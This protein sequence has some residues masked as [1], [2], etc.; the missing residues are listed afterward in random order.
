MFFLSS[1]SGLHSAA[2]ALVILAMLFVMVMGPLAQGNPYA[3]PAS[4]ALEEIKGE[5]APCAPGRL[6]A[7]APDPYGYQFIDSSEPGG[8]TFSWVDITATGTPLLLADDQY[9]GPFGIGFDFPLYGDVFTLFWVSSNGWINF[10]APTSS[11]LNNACPITAPD[12]AAQPSR[13]S[14]MHDD[15]DPGD[16]GDLLH[17]Q[18]FPSSPHPD[19]EGRCL[20]VT[21]D[22]YMH[23]N[24]SS[25][26]VA[27]TF[28]VLIFESGEIL[29]QFLDAGDEEGSG[30][31]T[32]IINGDM[33]IGLTYACNTP[34]SLTDNLAVRLFR[35]DPQER[36][37]YSIDASDPLLHRISPI[38]G[39][40]LRSTPI[41]LPGLEISGGTGLATHPQTG[42]LWALLTL[43]STASRELV[44][45]DPVTGLAT[46]IGSTGDRF[47]SIDFDFDGTL[48][49]VSGNGADNVTPEALY[50]LSTVDATSTYL[51]DGISGGGSQ[52]IAYNP[53]DRL[54]YHTAGFGVPNVSELFETITL[55]AGPTVNIPLSGFDYQRVLALTH[56][57]LGEFIASEGATFP[58]ALFTMSS[59]GTVTVIGQLDHFSRGLAFKAIPESRLHS[60]SVSDELIRQIDPATG[61]TIANVAMIVP[62]ET[63][64]AGTGL[65]THPLTGE[66]WA[67]LT[68]DG[69]FGS[70][71]VTVE[72]G[73]GVV[74]RIGDTGD[75]FAGLAFGSDSTL[76]GVTDDT[77]AFPEVL[78][79]LD[80][81]T[82]AAIPILVFGVGNDGETIASSP[83][84]GMIYH[85]SGRGVPNSD[86]RLQEFDPSVPSIASIPLLGDDYDEMLAMTHRGGNLLL[87]ADRG[88]QLI[89][90]TT[91]GRVTLLA[92]L[93]HLAKGLAF[94]SLSPPPV[95]PSACPA[96]GTLCGI[97]HSGPDG[98]SRLW[99]I[100]PSTGAAS[101]VGD[102]GF[103]AVTGLAFSSDGLLFGIG[104]RA[105]GSNTNVLITIDPC[106]GAGTEVGPTGI[107]GLGFPI[108]QDLSFRP[109]DGTLFTSLDSLGG[110]ALGTVDTATGAVTVA[111]PMNLLVP[112]LGNGIAFN[113]ESTLH[114]ANEASLNEIDQVTGN[115]VSLENLIFSPPADNLPRLNGLDYQPGTG[116]LFGSLDDGSSENYLANVT[117][118]TGDVTIIGPTVNDL[119]ALAF[120]PSADL[121]IVKTDDVDPVLAGDPLSYTLTVFNHGP[122]VAVSTEVIDTLPPG[123]TY[124]SH[125]A[126]QGTFTPGTGVWAV[127]DLA[128]APS[129][130]NGSFETGDFSG[131]TA[132]TTQGAGSVEYLPYRIATGGMGAGIVLPGVPADGTFFA[133]N[134]FDG[135]AGLMY[136]LYQEI[137][138]PAGA[139]RVELSWA[140][141]IQWDMFNFMGSTVSREYAVT[142]QPGGGGA[143]LATLFEMELPPATLGDTGYV[144]HTEDVLAAVPGLP[145]QT[146]RFNWH[147]MIPETMTG[148]GQFDLDA[149]S[150]LVES[151][152]ATLVID[153]TVDPT[154][155]GT[156]TNVATATSPCPDRNL[157]NNTATEETTVITPEIEVNPLALNFPT[158]SVTGPATGPLQVVIENIGTSPLNFTGIGFEIAGPQAGSFLHSG[159]PTTP[160]APGASREVLVTFDPITAGPQSAD[161]IITTDDADEATVAVSLTGTVEVNVGDIE[162]ALLGLIPATPSPEFNINADSTFDAADLVTE[163]N[164]P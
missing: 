100:D 162:A 96:A 4:T 113:S 51:T 163:V 88:P 75:I 63:V 71:L 45:I 92:P 131:W 137:A 73:T 25:G 29:L 111:G 3:A 56:Q 21:Y 28:Q 74:N 8:P 62:G 160:L 10:V 134:G 49:A 116:F 34:G 59:T 140:E 133:Q 143:P 118:G 53:D 122:S 58:P 158:T 138:I 154:T 41:T 107:E 89:N 110:D 85:A 123:V 47:S 24:G 161:L 15:L 104:E 61:A 86:E 67:L 150:L 43:D 72:P 127:G 95:P 109:S 141:R 79:T 50:T 90:L 78:F 57:S 130:T 91:D 151:P 145:G 2:R 32:G 119:D 106:T 23:F 128:A 33:T 14:I 39:R 156:I 66:M 83:L 93:D 142:V 103:E 13:I 48:Y 46:S 7:G 52:N 164:A 1:Q 87:G 159:P 37:L 132:V 12:P 147:E 65:A 157:T 152:A 97:T 155:V 153:L 36:A 70:E 99:L 55:P 126:S 80:Q 6:L 120:A 112:S 64:L 9:V 38:D 115:A 68:L 135:G 82:A 42:D 148:P 76:Y 11:N 129:L 136:D 5:E 94:T 18:S 146:V 30:S 44:T 17:C 26:I 108:A 22:D 19:F 144:N 20:V 102:I 81:T 117:P 125:T 149:I 16:T 31:T 40:T 98:L 105:D 101:L 84:S 27:G 124:Q 35:E 114:H 139:T 77:A 121:E 69:Q 54:M 60:V